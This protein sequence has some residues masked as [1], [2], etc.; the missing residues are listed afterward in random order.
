MYVPP[1]SPF[2]SLQ[3]AILMYQCD[4][5][6]PS[7][8]WK[9]TLKFPPH[10]KLSAECTD[11]LASLLCEPE[12]RLGSKPVTGVGGKMSMGIGQGTLT[13]R[14]KKG[15]GDDGSEGVKRH[16]WFKGVDW[17][18]ESPFLPFFALSL[19]LQNPLPSSHPSVSKM[20]RCRDIL[21]TT[22]YHELYLRPDT[23]TMAD[24]QIY[25]NRLHHTGPN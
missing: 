4:K 25:I 18:S 19:P 6:T 5:L 8:N 23:E 2:T 22:T 11:L 16:P 24:L 13:M 17:E 1:H 10:P 3:L 20:L 21:D 14:G 15:L 9:T 7:L 12:D